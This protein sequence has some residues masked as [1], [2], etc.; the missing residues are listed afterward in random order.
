MKKRALPKTKRQ[1][2]P[3]QENTTQRPTTVQELSQ[4]PEQIP[5]ASKALLE[6]LVQWASEEASVATSEEEKKRLIALK[7]KASNELYDRLLYT[8]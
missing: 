1:P 7:D 8:K 4:Q 2:T 3:T 6:E 5:D